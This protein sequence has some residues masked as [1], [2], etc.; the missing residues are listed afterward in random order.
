[1]KI[2]V[3]QLNLRCC[4]HGCHHLSHASQR[5]SSATVEPRYG[6]LDRL[7]QLGFFE[8]WTPV[9]NLPCGTDNSHVG[10]IPRSG[11]TI[12]FSESVS[13]A[14]VEGEERQNQLMQCLSGRSEHSRLQL[15]QPQSLRGREKKRDCGV[16]QWARRVPD[17]SKGNGKVPRGMCAMRTAVAGEARNDTISEQTV[18]HT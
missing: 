10:Q 11:R 18:G 16:Y 9:R 5:M 12:G 2:P 3:L 17:L 1:M 4:S 15:F 14:L 7:R 8:L 13:G 6:C